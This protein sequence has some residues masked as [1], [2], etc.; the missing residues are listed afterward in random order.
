VFEDDRERDTDHLDHGLITVR[1]T[2]I[3]LDQA[4]DHEGARLKRILD[5][6]G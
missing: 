6:G 4:P 2:K 5:R 3:R 1:I